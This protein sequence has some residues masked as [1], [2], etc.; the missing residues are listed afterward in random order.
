TKSDYLQSRAPFASRGGCFR[1]NRTTRETTSCR[2]HVHALRYPE[3]CGVGTRFRSLWVSYRDNMAPRQLVHLQGA[4]APRA[5]GGGE[6]HS[7]VD[8]PGLERT[9]QDPGTLGR[10]G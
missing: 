8:A 7:V 9:R 2:R 3:P 1:S 6:P 5:K 4:P 10:R